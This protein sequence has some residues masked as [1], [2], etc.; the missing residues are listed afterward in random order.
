MPQPQWAPPPSDLQLATGVVDVW[1]AD[2]TAAGARERA[3]LSADERARTD[4][5]VR[6]E[7]GERW[8]AARGILRALLA[9]YARADP[10][11]LR[12]EPGPHGKPALAGE[13]AVA[14]RADEIEPDRLRFNLSHSGD[15]ALYAVTLDRE[16]GVDIELPRRQV[17]AV[18]IARRV[19]GAAEAERLAALDP[20]ERA[21]AFL[22]AWVRWEAILKCHG[23]GIGGADAP[24]TGAEPWVCELDPGPPGAAALAVDPGPCEVRRWQWPA[25]GA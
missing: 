17:D 20:T 4:R 23:T 3:L 18:A 6:T 9:R 21:R 12:F 25:A 2:L 15:V 10:R 1:R 19:L 8:A 11:A 16:L 5:F 14:A 22:R 13:R 7:D 24:S